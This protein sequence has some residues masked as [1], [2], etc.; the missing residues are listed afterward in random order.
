M[1]EIGALDVRNQRLAAGVCRI[2]FSS[3]AE[4]RFQVQRSKLL[5]SNSEGKTLNFKY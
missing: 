1:K 2:T 5:E 3:E 4:S